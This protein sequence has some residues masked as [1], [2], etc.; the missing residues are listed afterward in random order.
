MIIWG[1]LSIF[2]YFASEIAFPSSYQLICLFLFNPD[3]C[4]IFS[5]FLYF[6]DWVQYVCGFIVVYYTYSVKKKK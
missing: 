1:G 6:S 4:F 2:L 3:F 5:L